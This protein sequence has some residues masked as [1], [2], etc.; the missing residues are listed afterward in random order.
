DK[1][2]KQMI[3][4]WETL[5]LPMLSHHTGLQS[6][7]EAEPKLAFHRNQNRGTDTWREISDFGKSLIKSLPAPKKEPD[8]WKREMR[9]RMLFSCLVDA[10]YLDTE[11]HF[12]PRNIGLRGIGTPLISLWPIFRANH[13]RLMWSTRGE[14]MSPHRATVYFES[15]KSASSPPGLFRLTVPTGGGKTRAVMAFALRHAVEN[16]QHGFRRI[17]SAIPYTSI[18]DQTADTYREIFGNPH[19]LEHHSQTPDLG[20]TE[21]DQNAARAILATENW[22]APIIVTT[23][24]QLFESLFSN[25]TSRCRKLHRIA[26]SILILDEVQTLPAE[27]LKPTLDALRVLV[28]DYGVT[29]VLCTATQPTFEES[30]YLPEF[31]SQ[32]PQEIVPKGKIS[33]LFK[34]LNRVTYQP[35]KDCSEDSLAS[36]LAESENQQCLAIFNTR[37]DAL[38]VYQVLLKKDLQGLYHLSTLLCSHHRKALLKKVTTRL[39][40]GKAVRLIST[41]VVEA[42]VDLDFPAVYRQI[43]P[44][45]RIVQAAG[46]CNRE[47]LLGQGGGKVIIFRLEGGGAPKGAYAMGMELANQMLGYTRNLSQL[48]SPEIFRDYFTRLFTGISL[49]KHEIQS[50]RKR[51]DYPQVAEKYHFIEPTVQVV[52]S[53]YDPPAIDP[54]IEAHRYTPTR[55]TW[56]ALQPYTVNLMKWE[57]ERLLVGNA[58]EIR[59]DLWKWNGNYDK[60]NHRGIAAEYEPTDL[61]VGT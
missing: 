30:F 49:D 7:D 31:G 9:L 10:D 14:T 60:I 51:M 19:V 56:R 37:K 34:N 24:V 55:S 2:R 53:N 41:Q 16:T 38:R 40:Q 48:N 13:L 29:V 8:P 33:T 32:K 28:E 57:A 18:V 59:G 23:T 21:S 46:R 20:G 11:A 27:L 17:I 15:K 58:E 44:L 43:A 26:K 25:K 12:T 42:G 47:F 4:N 50:L 36:E 45:D 35:I 1:Q 52:V 61:Y 5:L 54:L 6:L 39:K 3:E 22:D